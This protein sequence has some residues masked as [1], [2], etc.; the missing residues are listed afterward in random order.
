MQ[1]SRKEFNKPRIGD[2]LASEIDDII[3]FYMS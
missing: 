1:G 2:I 3:L